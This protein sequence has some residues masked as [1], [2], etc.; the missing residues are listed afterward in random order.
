M[1]LMA[2]VAPIQS[3]KTGQL[4]Q[5]V[6]ELN[7]PRRREYEEARRQYGVRERIFL[8]STPQGDMVVVTL[9]G[10]DPVD[11]FRRW[12]GSNDPFVQWFSQQV[13]E[14]HGFNLG[15]IVS[16]PMPQFVLDS[17]PGA[18]QQRMAA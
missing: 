10:D 4:R 5:F 18:G 9:E 17:E 6:Q 15:Q 3:G 7:G 2:F 16:Q 13:Q 11:S 12:A 14:I 8:Q 1:A